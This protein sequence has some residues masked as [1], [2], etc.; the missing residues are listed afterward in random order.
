MQNRKRDTD[1]QNR[2]LDSVGE[3]KGGMFWENSIETCILSRVKQIT[4]RGWMYETSAGAGALICTIVWQKPTQHCKAISLQFKNKFTKRLLD[5]H[6]NRVYHET[7]TSILILLCDQIQ[8]WVGCNHLCKSEWDALICVKMGKWGGYN[9]LCKKLKV[10]GGKYIHRIFVTYT[11]LVIL[12]IFKWKKKCGEQRW[13]VSLIC[14]ESCEGSFYLFLSSSLSKGII[15]SVLIIPLFW[16]EKKKRR[17]FPGSPMV[18]TSSFQCR[19]SGELRSHKSCSMDEKKKE[20]GRK[21]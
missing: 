11:R 3:G 18:R 13:S 17:E 6:F 19:G 21:D 10:W 2:L 20:E 8:K 1:V 14:F 5:S 7:W 4:S 12:V 15:F 9:H 16:L